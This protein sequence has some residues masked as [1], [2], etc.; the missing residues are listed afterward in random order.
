MQDGHEHLVQ[1]HAQHRRLVN[2][3]AGVGAVVNRLAAAGDAVDGEHRKPVLL[4]VITGVVAIRA[5]QRRQK[6]FLLFQRHAMFTHP[7]KARLDRGQ[8]AFQHDFGA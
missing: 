3:L 5:F 8:P 1:R 7:G 4:V 2:R 6:A